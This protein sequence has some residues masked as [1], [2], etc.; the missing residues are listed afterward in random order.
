MKSVIV[1]NIQIQFDSIDGSLE[2]IHN[3]LDLIN[4]HL[5]LLNDFQP[6]LF[7]SGVDDGDIEIS[8]FDE[9]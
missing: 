8:N 7:T 5:Q 3:T 1:K 4:S 2:D 6:Q 9:D